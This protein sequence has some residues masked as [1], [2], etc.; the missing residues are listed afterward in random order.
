MSSRV[1]SLQSASSGP[2][3]STTSAT[4]RVEPAAAPLAH[5]LLRRREAVCG[6]EHLERLAE[7]GDARE[8]RDLVALQAGR[9]AAAVPVLVERAHGLGGLG[10]EAEPRDDRRAAVAARLDDRLA[11]GDER[12]QHRERALGARDAAAGGD[13]LRGVARDL[14]GLR[15]VDELAVRLERDVVGAEELAHAR[16]RRRA[17]DVLEQQRVV[18]RIALRRRELQLG[19]DAH[20]DQA[21]ALGLPDRDGPRSCRARA[22]APRSPPTA[23]LRRARPA[24]APCSALIGSAGRH[25]KCGGR[26]SPVRVPRARPATLTRCHRSPPSSCSRSRRSR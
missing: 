3:A 10:G 20:A 21:R 16:G 7:A 18:E 5:H 12:A 26:N 1:R 23:A 4:A 19:C 2:I 22:R 15:P 25:G 13:V 9:L 17:A 14:R 8:Q 6:E 11:L 24:P